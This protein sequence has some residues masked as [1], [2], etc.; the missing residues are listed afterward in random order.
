MWM[1]FLNPQDMECVEKNFLDNLKNRKNI[2]KVGFYLDLDSFFAII[3][4]VFFKV[5]E[6]DQYENDISAKK[7][8]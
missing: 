3:E 2:K 6:V 5:E 1:I 7:K 8:A 4:M